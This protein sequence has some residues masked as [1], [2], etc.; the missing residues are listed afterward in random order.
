MEETPTEETTATDLPKDEPGAASEPET[1]KPAL[2]TEQ[3]EAA[4]PPAVPT[5]ADPPLAEP[6]EF[7]VGLWCGIPNYG[8][9]Y[10][11]YRTLEGSGAVELHILEK[12]GRANPRHMKALELK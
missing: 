3:G 2:E 11:L 8:C 12:I 1:P 7:Y 9:P 6:G 5:P 4:P 10:C